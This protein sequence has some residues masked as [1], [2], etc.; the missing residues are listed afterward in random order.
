MIFDAFKLTG[1]WG[2]GVL[3]LGLARLGWYF[4]EALHDGGEQ[5]A[6]ARTMQGGEWVR[7][8]QP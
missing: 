4:V 5:V 6:S 3:G 7:L 8:A 1:F 2:F